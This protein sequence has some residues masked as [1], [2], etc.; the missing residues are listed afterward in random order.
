M[1]LNKQIEYIILQF[2]F[3]RAKEILSFL[4]LDVSVDLLAE[5]ARHCLKMAIVKKEDYEH[6]NFEVIYMEVPNFMKDGVG[7][8]EKVPMIELKLVVQRCNALSYKISK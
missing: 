5:R 4:G 3:H 7:Q 1:E 2:D 8:P 6:H